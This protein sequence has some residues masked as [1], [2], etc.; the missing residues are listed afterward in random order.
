MRGTH[1]L[2]WTLRP[3]RCGFKV[4]NSESP[5]YNSPKFVSD[6]HGEYAVKCR[7]CGHESPFF[8]GNKILAR[9]AW[10]KLTKPRSYL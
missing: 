8:M 6:G 4:Y 5:E 3:C 10:N 2:E 1:D 7:A 9:A